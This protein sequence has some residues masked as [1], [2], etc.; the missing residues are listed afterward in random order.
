MS[1]TK[2]RKPAGRAKRGKSSKA[3]GRVGKG[4]AN[5][6]GANG[7]AGNA[8]SSGAGTSS[9]RSAGGQFT[10]GN[11]FGR[12]RPPRA[13]EAQYLVAMHETVLLSDWMEIVE[14]A[15]IDAKDGDDKARAW[16]SN[17][18][19][20]RPIDQ[21]ARTREEDER[22]EFAAMSDAEL[23]ELAR[24]AYTYDDDPDTDPDDAD[25]DPA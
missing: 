3:A 19:I 13:T 15:M 16:L 6:S 23:H 14:R 1:R 24:G 11:S 9:G 22:K 8:S 20:G 12:G 2:V 17:Y 5:G 4:V 10:A 25:S 7:G 21:P 18:L